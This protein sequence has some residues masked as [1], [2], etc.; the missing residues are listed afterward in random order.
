MYAYGGNANASVPSAQALRFAAAHG[1]AD[2]FS[3]RDWFVPPH[4]VFGNYLP[5]ETVPGRC[6][7]ADP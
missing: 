1:S 2:A 4:F 3:S 7:T 5:Y 6:N